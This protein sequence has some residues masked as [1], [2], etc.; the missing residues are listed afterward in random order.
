MSTY[1]IIFLWKFKT[2]AEQI[3]VRRVGVYPMIYD[4]EGCLNMIICFKV[5][6]LERKFT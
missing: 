1:D 3:G 6:N 4:K 5:D 2:V